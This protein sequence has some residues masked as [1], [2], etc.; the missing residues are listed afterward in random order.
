M[1]EEENI[2]DYIERLDEIINVVEGLGEEVD[3]KIIVQR[4]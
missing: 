4:C 2:E 3:E 1:R